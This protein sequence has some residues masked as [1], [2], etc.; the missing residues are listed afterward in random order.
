MVYP[1][2][3]EIRCGPHGHAISFKKLSEA[4]YG[5]KCVD[6]GKVYLFFPAEAHAHPQQETR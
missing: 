5:L 4:E 3:Q 6:C 2:R 1:Q